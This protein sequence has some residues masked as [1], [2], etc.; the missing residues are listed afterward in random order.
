LNDER[1]VAVLLVGYGEVEEYQNF[2]AYNEMALRLLTA[3]F[4]KIPEFGFKLLAGTLARKDRREWAG[5]DNFRS[6][7]N[8]VFE[9]QRAGIARH[10]QE[11]FG[12]RVEVF[13]AFNF[14]EGYLPQQ[15]LAQI[16]A[17]GFRRL[18]IYPLLVIDSIFTSGLALQ[19]I[20]EA[21]A[22]EERWVDALRYLPSFYNESDFHE[23][24]ASHIEGHL[25]RLCTRHQPSRIG[26]VLVNHGS[27]YEVKG[28]TTG[29]EESQFLYERV[30]ERLI[31]RYPLIS[32]GWLNHDT[33]GKWT[34]PDVPQAA[35]NL[36]TVGASALLFCP[37]GFVTENHETILDVEAIMQ[38]FEQKAIPCTRLDCLNDDPQF[39][40]AAAGWVE[41]LVGELLSVRSGQAVAAQE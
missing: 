32:I 14:C 8:D 5:R 37:I 13:K 2:A 4:L 24:L 10:L 39:L 1:R 34:T 25:Q 36:L 29:I 33:P 28:F 15:V 31:T 38:R 30:R 11:Y 6:P 3:K 22:E 19:Q 7:H 16:R 35:R 17:R 41:P 9:A 26:I 40:A 20:N 23:R 21:L 27:P 18:L 12:E